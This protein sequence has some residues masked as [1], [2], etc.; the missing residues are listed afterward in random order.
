MI[1]NGL[2][3]N[4]DV[5]WYVATRK[6]TGAHYLLN[7]FYI[8]DYEHEFI[9]IREFEDIEEA[10]A[11]LEARKEADIRE[12]SIETPRKNIRVSKIRGDIR[13]GS[14]DD[15]AGV[16]PLIEAPPEPVKKTARK[17]TSTKPTREKLE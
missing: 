15:E 13:R 8:E 12:M 3:K 17:S 5:M 11:A 7:E 9:R 4:T 1:K 10:K 16:P 2:L 6:D 14:V